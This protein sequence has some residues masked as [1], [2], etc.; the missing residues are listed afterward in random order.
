MQG[1]TGDGLAAPQPH[2]GVRSH[3]LPNDLVIA[4]I[5][6]KSIRLGWLVAGLVGGSVY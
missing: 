2:V 5:K 6:T 3:F 4:N 1:D